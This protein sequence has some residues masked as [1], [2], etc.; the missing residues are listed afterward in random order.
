MI[1]VV[2]EAENNKI[3]SRSL[4]ELISNKSVFTHND[5]QFPLSKS[6]TWLYQRAASVVL[7]E[8]LET[9]SSV[10][11]NHNKL[12]IFVTKSNEKMLLN[13]NNNWRKKVDNEARNK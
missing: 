5:R 9:Q 11:I 4:H 10:F 8:K 1:I 7:C 3:A 13:D 6:R 12:L 2:S